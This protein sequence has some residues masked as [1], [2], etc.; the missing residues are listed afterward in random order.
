MAS[1]SGQGPPDFD[2][3]AGIR[4]DRPGSP[5]KADDHPGCRRGRLLAPRRGDEAGTLAALKSLRQTR[6]GTAPGRAPRPHRQADGRRPHRG[7]RLRRRRGGLRGGDP[8]GDWPSARRRSRP[9]AGSSC[10]SASTSATWS[11]RATISS[12]TASTSPPGSSSLPARRRLVSGTAH[13]QLQGKLDCPLRATRASSASRTSRGRCGPTGW[14]ST[15]APCPGSR[16]LPSPT[17]P[18]S[19]SCRSTT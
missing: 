16:R 1:L 3:M 11:S 13:D 18:R 19:P 7:V 8:D 10:A 14:C 9:S 2:R 6:A 12:A 4:H 15:C 17:S 5:T